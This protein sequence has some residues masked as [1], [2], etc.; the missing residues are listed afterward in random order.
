MPNAHY[1]MEGDCHWWD[2]S[3]DPASHYKAAVQQCFFNI[4]S[5]FGIAYPKDS[6]V[7]PHFYIQN[8][9]FVSRRNIHRVPLS[10]WKHVYMQHIVHGT[11]HRDGLVNRSFVTPDAWRRHDKANVSARDLASSHRQWSAG[12]MVQKGEGNS[13]PVYQQEMA[14]AWEFMS[15]VV[16]GGEPYISTAWDDSRWCAAFRSDCEGS[17]CSPHRSR[18]LQEDR[19][20]QRAWFR[21]RHVQPRGGVPHHF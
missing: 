17:P 18:L 20:P 6:F 21:R 4:A 10:T 2:D 8:K 3:N 14:A 15:N 9:F 16:F 13:I 19:Q 7:C 12:P 1:F 11:C 5:A